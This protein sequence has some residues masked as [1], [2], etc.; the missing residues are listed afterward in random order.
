M[1]KVTPKLLYDMAEIIER[2]S[3]EIGRESAAAGTMF[4]WMC[5]HIA[6]E[7]EDSARKFRT[8]SYNVCRGKGLGND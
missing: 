6:T 3:D 4:S 8:T 7:Y 1:M 5:D 2:L